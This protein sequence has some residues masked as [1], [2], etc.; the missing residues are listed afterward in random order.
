MRIVWL[1][2]RKIISNYTLTNNL[3]HC[4]FPFTLA[5][6][7]SVLL[8]FFVVWWG[9]ILLLYFIHFLVRLSTFLDVSWLFVF[10]LMITNSYSVESSHL[11]SYWF[12]SDLF[13]EKILIV[14]HI[15]WPFKILFA[16]QFCLLCLMLHRSFNFYIVKSSDCFLC[17]SK[18]GVILR[19][20]FSTLKFKCTLSFLLVT[21]WLSFKKL[22]L[23]SICD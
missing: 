22:N 21:L 3:W 19:K 13:I 12:I 18:V 20:G 23:W 6:L 4:S 1:L 11:S 8:I 14:C 2:S 16:F 17:C 15:Y 7:L 5:R 9:R 10:L